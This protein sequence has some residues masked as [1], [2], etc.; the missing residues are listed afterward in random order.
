MAAVAAVLV[1]GAS[2]AHNYKDGAF[3]RSVLVDLK[4]NGVDVVIPWVNCSAELWRMAQSELKAP[5]TSYGMAIDESGFDLRDASS[6]IR[7]NIRSYVKHAAGMVNTIY[8][9]HSDL[10]AP[11]TFL[12]ESDHLLSGGPRLKFVRHSEILPS[13][14]LPTFDRTTIASAVHRIGALGEWFI[15]SE[16]DAILVRPLDFT[17]LANDTH[18]WGAIKDVSHSPTLRNRWLSEDIIGGGQ[19]FMYSPRVDR[20]GHY[21]VKPLDHDVVHQLFANG[22]LTAAYRGGRFAAFHTNAIGCKDTWFKAD[23]GDYPCFRH[24]KV[25]QSVVRILRTFLSMCTQRS[26]LMWVNVQGPGIDDCYGGQYY[27]KVNPLQKVF[28]EWT[29]L[30]FPVASAFETRP[31]A[32]NDQTTIAALRQLARSQ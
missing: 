10:H 2:G 16:D 28:S 14:T 31:G 29:W 7:F 27:N 19:K 13:W 1:V 5:F 22:P 18:V 17:K 15:W 9:V 20:S 26:E 25:S 24:G 4:A 3:S 12:R 32:V 23:R 30:T 21:I 11:P 6:E 8:V